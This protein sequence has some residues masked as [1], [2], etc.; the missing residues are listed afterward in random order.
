M[1]QVFNPSGTRA[2]ILGCGIFLPGDPIPNSDLSKLMDT[3]DDWIRTRTGIEQRYWVQGK[4]S[5]SDLAF[6]ASKRAL[7]NAKVEAK[8]IDLILLA[9]LYPDHEIPGA[10]LFL[11]RKLGLSGIPALDIRQQCSGFLYAMS[12]ADSF[13]RMGMSKKVLVVASEVQSKGLD[14]TT[15]GRDTAVLFGDGAGA[16]VIGAKTVTDAKKD[17]FIY[18]HHLHADGNFAESLWI[19]S[20]G[21]NTEGHRITHEI[22]DQGGA[23][24]KMNGKIVFQNAVTRMPEVLVEG[25]NANGL[26]I[27]DVDLFVFHQA[28]IRINDYVADKLKIPSHKIHNTIH[29]FG[30]TTAATIPLGFGD[31]IQAGKLKKGDLVA[32]AAFGAGFTWAASVL[33]W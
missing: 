20:P 33:R 31:A 11:Q 4:V 25:L 24:L 23:D 29:K 9:C 26:T 3:S 14:R 8:E 17:S 10:S 12:I 7:E 27:D 6:E 21:T 15:K 16:V 32:T 30:N 22:L 28:N 19:P 13:I 1:S 2:E 18:S 5:T